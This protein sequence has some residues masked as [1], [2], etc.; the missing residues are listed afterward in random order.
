MVVAVLEQLHLHTPFKLKMRCWILLLSLLHFLSL[1]LGHCPAPCHCSSNTVDCNSKD[2]TEESLPAAFPQSTKV[3][4]LKHNS[5]KALPN[6]LFDGLLGL[7]EVHLQQNPWTCDCNILYLRSWIQ[8]QQSREL[9]RDVVCSSPPSMR[10]RLIMYLTE[11]EVLSTC[12]YWHCSLALICQI[13]LFFFI[14]LQAILLIFV[15]IFLR[16]F[17]TIAKEARGTTKEIY[18]NTDAYVYE[19]FSN[20]AHPLYNHSRT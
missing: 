15:I 12:Q 19:S 10:G 4:R 18:Q 14:T 7:Q 2:L 9:Y 17:Q 11:D 13:C 6:G 20:D 8:K 1:V 5:L 3:I 16:R